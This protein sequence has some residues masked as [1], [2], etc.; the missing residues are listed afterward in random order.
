MTGVS[1]ERLEKSFGSFRALSGVDLE[2]DDGKLVTL[3][4]PSGCGKTTLLRCIAGILEQSSGDIRFGRRLMNE[5]PAER[6]NIGMIFQTYA[7]FPH[8][9][10][11]KN[12]A[13]GLEMRKVPKA[14]AHRRIGAALD[15]VELGA[16]AGR[17][18]RELSGGQQQRVALARA[19]VIEPDVLL[20]DEPLSN[21]DAR[22][23]DSLRED[24]R[25][26]QRRLGITSIYVTHDQAEALALADHIV[27]MHQG[28][29]VEQGPPEALYRR[30]RHRY[31]AEF[32]GNTNVVPVEV[33]GNMVRLPWGEVRPSAEPAAA[34]PAMASLRAEDIEVGRADGARA[35][36][37]DVTFMG[38]GIQYRVETGG[39]ALR[40]VTSGGTQEILPRGATVQVSA[41]P[42]VRLLHDHPAAAVAA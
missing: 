26:L 38:A 16:L 14:E 20:F 23:R 18:P 21:L 5:V 39:V 2:I 6:R 34:G 22:L 13:F 42:T 41:P 40:I 3:L 37:I 10:V 4:G 29:I 8:M 28:R 32:L 27:L 11:Y 24:L 19:I 30:P 31:T 7:L 17:Y 36:V 33:A 1:I 12:L 35:T 25:S 15:L 9:T